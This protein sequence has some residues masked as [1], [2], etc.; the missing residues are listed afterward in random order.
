MLRVFAPVLLLTALTL[1]A[2]L[3]AESAPRAAR[4]KKYALLVGVTEYKHSAFASLKYTENDVEKL[5]EVLLD[6]NANFTQ[7]RVL[8]T[9][10]GK[11]DAKEAPT[12]ANVSK[13]MAD[14]VA[15]KNKDD[16]VLV[17]L[18]GPAVR[19]E[20]ADPAAKGSPKS[21]TS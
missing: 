20:S 13:A 12:A 10:R 1:S 2:S 19:L 17:A 6:K 15:D 9:S 8:T 4:G 5:A 3:S 18:A 7:V 11:K 14:L 16:V 21:S